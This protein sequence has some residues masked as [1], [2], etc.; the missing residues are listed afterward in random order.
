MN[1]RKKEGL[2]KKSV[3]DLIS[4]SQDVLNQAIS[5]TKRTPSPREKRKID[6]SAENVVP[7]MR[8]SSTAVTT[9]ITTNTNIDADA[10]ST[11]SQ[12]EVKK[13][14][15]M[16]LGEK[17]KK[18]SWYNVIYPS[19][20]SRSEDFKKLF[21]L[22]EDER[23]LVDYSCAIQKDILVHG[24]MYVSSNFV[25]FHANIIVYETRFVLHWKDV[26]AISKEK[27][28]KVIPNAILITTENEKY[29]LTSFTSRDKTYLMLFRLWQNAL[30]NSPMNPQELWQWIHTCYGEQL[31]LTSD[32]DEDY[33][34]P[35]NYEERENL[36]SADSEAKASSSSSSKL[37][38][39]SSSIKVKKETNK[40]KNSSSSSSSLII[41][42][43]IETNLVTAIEPQPLK[44]QENL[45]TDMSGSSSE[46]DSGNN[47]MDTF[48]NA[49]CNSMHEGRQ[50]VHTI[51]PLSI[52][53]VFGLLFHKSK[54]F[55]EFHKMRKTENLV[56]GDWEDQEDG[57]K[58]RVQKLTVAITQMVGP[59]SSHVTETQTL[60]ACSVPGVLYS[61]DAISENAGIPY[62]DSFY[63]QVHYCMKKSV[64]DSTV[65]SVHAQIKY[66]KS[67][68]GVVKGFIEKNTWL[69]LEDF[70]DALSQALIAEYNIPPAKAKR[71]IRKST[72]SH[73][74]QILPNVN[75]LQI[76]FPSKQIHKEDIQLA[77]QTNIRGINQ[78]EK[79]TIND[80]VSAVSI[81]QE[82]LSYIVIF[83][84][85]TLITFN[86]ILYFKLWKL[87][88]YDS[89]D[90]LSKTSPKTT[91][92]W[93]KLL[94]LQEKLHVKEMREWHEV[95]QSAIELLKKTENSLV[96]LQNLIL[97]FR[98]KSNN[99]ENYGSANQ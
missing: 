37:T 65:M 43:P 38:N 21:K 90:V 12:D 98:S 26:K 92:D 79:S 70:Y 31:G 13:S 42:K 5:L 39:A 20:K 47:K 84:L 45:P 91:N 32:D 54:F 67:V 52:D 77:K 71:R 78:I 30:M 66:K 48:V 86:V 57:T 34:D 75:K 8:Q 19:Y 73:V 63:V 6:T 85:I 40:S 99:N 59:K 46:S 7:D 15:N 29:F 95:I 44:I 72:S 64:D 22:P 68:W 69:G 23:L 49:E 55:T 16:K 11:K 80:N 94:T 96:D 51:L 60:R 97:T 33:I 50:L 2:M 53:T 25:C 41:L 17:A 4:S 82:K 36:N 35:T 62:A 61:I 83:L 87:E 56:Q 3:D 27:V 81:K 89:H 18:K 93:M 14:Q 74:G 88:E 76:P 24:R 1:F 58:K 28:A 10:A 9:M